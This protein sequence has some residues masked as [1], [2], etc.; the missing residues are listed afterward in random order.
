MAKRRLWRIVC[1]LH[2]T[3]KWLIANCGA[4][5]L[6]VQS[7]SRSIWCGRVEF[8]GASLADYGSWAQ[9]VD[10][11]VCYANGGHGFV[12]CNLCTSLTCT[13][14]VDL[15]MNNKTYLHVL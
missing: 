10:P 3:G 15:T 5:L 6:L 9:D 1:V 8:L 11:E 14:D 7:S 4:S 2:D 13:Q 12:T